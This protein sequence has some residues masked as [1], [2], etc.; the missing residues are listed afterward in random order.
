MWEYELLKI[1]EG[2]LQKVNTKQK[3]KIKK[4]IQSSAPSEY[5]GQ[6]FT[7]L[8][9]LIKELK[10]L[11][12]MKSDKKLSKKLSKIDEANISLTTA[13]SEL[14]KDYEILYRQLRGT[15]YPKS[16]GELGEEKDE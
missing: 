3:K 6:D 10:S 12:V 2:L 14:R 5:M 1:D 8:D 11:G 9:D 15:V 13:A 7:K 4:L 16:K